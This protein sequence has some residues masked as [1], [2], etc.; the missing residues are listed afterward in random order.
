M[1]KDSFEGGNEK[2]NP[3]IEKIFNIDYFAA[4]DLGHA[5]L[6]LPSLFPPFL[7]STV[8]I[9]ISCFVSCRQFLCVT[10]LP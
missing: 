5:F 9:V 7:L 4:N 1:N 3:C 6:F 8:A 2:T 10:G